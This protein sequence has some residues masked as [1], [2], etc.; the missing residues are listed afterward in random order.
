MLDAR[1]FILQENAAMQTLDLRKQLKHLYSP[2]AKQPAFVD[3][4]PMQFVLIKGAI[5]Q[6]F[7]PGT[8]PAFA[9]ALETLYGVSYTLKFMS[10]QQSVDAVDYPVMPLEALWWI[11]QGE[12]DYSRKD[13]WCWQAMI[14]Q[15]DHITCEMFAAAVAK[16]RKKRPAPTSLDLLRFESYDEGTCV[17][18]MH[19]GPYS[20]E[21]ATIERMRV[22]AA[23]QGYRLLYGH[24]EIYLGDPRRG[25]QSSL[26]TVL[27]YSI[28]S[29]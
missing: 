24:H 17:Q 21:P 28:E 18:M 15:P 3:V 27:R 10:K 6:G 19:R 26:K 16:L 14:M 11:E 23:S 8:S 4:P 7:E 29:L 5:E 1:P 25:D 22:F 20:D 13:N 12:F 2:S 9:S